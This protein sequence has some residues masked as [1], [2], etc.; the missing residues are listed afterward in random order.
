MKTN[1]KLQEKREYLK[2]LSKEFKRVLLHQIANN[3]T[4]MPK[5]LHFVATNI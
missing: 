2:G 1:S 3:Q 5:K 4:I